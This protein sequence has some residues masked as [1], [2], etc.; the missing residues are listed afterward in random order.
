M[1]KLYLHAGG[2]KTGST[3]IQEYLKANRAHLAERGLLVPEAG[4]DNGGRHLPLVRALTQEEVSRK[5]AASPEAVAA[6]LAAAPDRDAVISCEVLENVL[7]ATLPF[8]RSLGREVTVVL[9][10]RNQPQRMNS[11]YAQEARMLR[12]EHG[13]L[14]SVMRTLMDSRLRHSSWLARAD[15]DP[16]EIMFRPYAGA[17]RS[18]VIGDF[19][20]TLGIDR[21]G[22][23][24]T[25][26]TRS[27]T[28]LSAVGVAALRM[29]SRWAA[30]RALTVKVPE[31][32]A[33]VE[34]VEEADAAL[35]LPPFQGF[36]PAAFD[37]VVR[38]Y[39]GDNQWFA[40]QAWGRSWTEVFAAD[41]VPLD[42]PT[43]IDIDGE[44]TPELR[45]ARDLF[46]TIR[47]KYMETARV[48]DEEPDELP[49]LGFLL[50]RKIDRGRAAD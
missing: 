34:L 31:R 14:D 15:L 35:G 8:F 26:A 16:G 40:Q 12:A 28:A 20:A 24:S 7:P 30:D 38:N 1:A 17:I 5:V 23:P 22:L 33:I 43:E 48:A 49:D 50:E 18:D 13:F 19:L 47:V 9:Y 32:N 6:E 42:S 2:F 44:R 3:A 41:L 11:A 4:A 27:N 45:Q 46:H 37:Y 29:L 21:T 10:V 39:H 36:D 25:E